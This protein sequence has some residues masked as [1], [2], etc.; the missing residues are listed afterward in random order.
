MRFLTALFVGALT[1][2]GAGSVQAHTGAGAIGGLANGIVHPF[3]GP[4]DVLAMVLI[5]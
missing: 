2:L 1:L 5:R 3:T 4:D